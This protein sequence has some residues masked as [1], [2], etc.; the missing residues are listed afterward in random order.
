MDTSSPTSPSAAPHTH[1]V[2]PPQPP[3]T[4]CV[5]EHATLPCTS[6]PLHVLIVPPGPT[7][8]HVCAW[9]TPEAIKTQPAHPLG[10]LVGL[11]CATQTHH[12]LCTPLPHTHDEN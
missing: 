3:Q 5:F 10:H 1:K 8:T 4:L 2:P 12:L 9:P 11:P 7:I 6:E